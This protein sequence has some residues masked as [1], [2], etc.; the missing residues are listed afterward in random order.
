MS[1]KKHGFT[2]V[3][4]LIVI[5]VIAILAAIAIVSYVGIQERARD[6][7]RL[8]DVQAITKA[9]ELYYADHGRYPES[10]CGAACPTPKKIN[11]SWATTS[12][13]TW[14]ILESALVPRY[15][16]ELPVD[17]QSSTVTNAS[18]YGGFNYDYV[19]TG[20]WCN[21]GGGQ[22]YLLSYRLESQP[23]RN[24]LTGSCTSG[25][26]PTDYSSSEYIVVRGAP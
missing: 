9:L 7:Q 23:Q 19:L 14:D 18:I 21:T 12:D 2:I 13:G 22:V 10:A 8:Q 24:E 4:L 11:S 1:A 25:V 15:I 17:P 16:S 6:S 3:E 5:V 20:G 26:Y